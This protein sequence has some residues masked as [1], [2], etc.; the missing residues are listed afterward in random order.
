[1]SQ[2]LDWPP[3]PEGFL[4]L[5][6]SLSWIF[7]IFPC[8]SSAFEFS[9]VVAKHHSTARKQPRSAERVTLAVSFNSLDTILDMMT[10]VF[11]D[12]CGCCP[13]SSAV[14]QAGIQQIWKYANCIDLL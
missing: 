13:E 2:F 1:L 10:N 11:R 12:D 14:V 7:D 8:Y 4:P 5:G 6:A 3:S 9:L